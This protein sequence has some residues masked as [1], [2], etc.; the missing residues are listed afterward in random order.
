MPERPLKPC[1]VP[2]CPGRAETGRCAR[3]RNDRQGNTRLRVDTAAQ[4]GY[5]A[6]WRRR[7]ADYL[8]EHPLCALCRRL[9]AVADHYP[10]SRRQLLAEGVW[11]PDADEHLRPLCKPCHD[12]QT[13]LRQP[14][15]WR[16]QTMP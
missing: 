14:G 6:R 13:G 9:A 3:C 15:G 5:D 7:R 1:T 16:Q 8:V 10:I 11:D 2:G 4:R 12:R